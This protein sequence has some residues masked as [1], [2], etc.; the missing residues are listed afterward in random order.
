MVAMLLDLLLEQVDSVAV[1]V[2]EAMLET[3]LAAQEYFIFFTRRTL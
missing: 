1:A 3:N 2:V